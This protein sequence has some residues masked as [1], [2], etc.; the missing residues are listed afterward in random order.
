MTTKP[1]ATTKDVVQDALREWAESAERLTDLLD[2]LEHEGLQETITTEVRK[3]MNRSAR[4][5]GQ[6]Q[7]FHDAFKRRNTR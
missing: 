2:A 3:F 4:I 6:L 1:T 5:A 7:G